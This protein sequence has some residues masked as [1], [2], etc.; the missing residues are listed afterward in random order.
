MIE[1]RDFTRTFGS[2]IAVENMSLSIGKGVVYGLL[3][4]NGAGKTT[5]VKTIV[6]ALNPTVGEIIIDGIN[7]ADDPIKAK[8]I[9][10]Y[11][12]ENPS[13]FKSLT[14]REYL[15]L[16]GNLYHIEKT[17]LKEKAKTLL[18]QFGLYEKRDEQIATYSKGM[19]QKLV[20]AAAIIHNPRVLILDEPLT[21]LDAKA[22]AILKEIIRS[23]A[24]NGKTVLFSSHILD[25]VEKLCDEIAILY[26]G[27]L[28][29]TGTAGHIME[30]TGCDTLEKGFI[31]LTGETDISKEAADI[32]A[33]LE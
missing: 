11:V 28:L 16:T 6:G 1:I 18:T 21:G 22:S 20:I 33:A 24:R 2:L 5:T 7:L 31:K 29:A 25:I 17:I 12:P 19:A 23:F 9:I 30:T 8:R 15:Y 4:P 26:K 32:V 3:G 13:L 27:K 10:G 14:G